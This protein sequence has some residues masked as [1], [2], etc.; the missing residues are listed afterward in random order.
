MMRV[1]L[2]VYLCLS[3]FSS[4]VNGKGTN[5]ITIDDLKAWKKLL[6]SR[7]NVLTMFASDIKIAQPLLPVLDNVA[8][9]VKGTG[10]VAFVDC[11]DAKKLCK[12][13]KIIPKTYL[14]KHYKDGSFHKDYDRRLQ[15]SSFLNFLNDPTSEAPWSEDE[16][17]K[18]VKHIDSSSAFYKFIG[19]EQRPLLIMFYAPWCGH[20]KKMKPEF[21][22]AATK[23][24]GKAV[25]AG[26][27]VDKPDAMLVREEFNITGFPTVLYFEGGQLLYDYWGSRDEAGIIEWMKNPQ[28]PPKREEQTVEANWAGELENIV[29][30][31]I[32]NFEEFVKSNPSV[33]VA[34]Y[35]PWCGHCKAMKPDYNIAAKIMEQEKIQGKLAA[36][37][38]T[39]EKQ[40]ASMFEVKGFPTIKYF[41]NGN[42]VYDYGYPRST[43]AFIDFMKDPKPPPPPEKEWSEIET[44]VHHLT[45]DDFK[46]FLKKTKHVLVMFYA[47]WCG[48]CKAA[49]PHFTTAAEAFKAERK[50]SFAAVDCT[51][52]PSTCT[53]HDVQGYP[54]IVYFNYGKKSFK[55]MGPRTEAG[56][57]EFMSNPDSFAPIV[58]DEF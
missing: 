48:H 25:L 35:A 2:T 44:E 5:I 7:N 33:L 46:T 52:Y 12:T 37:D 21:A 13:L 38:A 56:F 53:S 40:L 28:P 15:K 11:S 41:Q 18:D 42:F 57:V 4:G 23:L 29:H 39:S 1:I 26:M 9:S 43:E 31:T 51:K 8:E 58:K 16:T 20:C 19:K 14:L 22:Q 36:V 32:E 10:S 17:A 3:V 24:K 55:Y 50:T 6:R 54:T 27:D 47:P 34:F 30:L 45:D 49:K